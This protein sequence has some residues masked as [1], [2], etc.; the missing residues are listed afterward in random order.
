MATIVQP[1]TLSDQQRRRGI[2]ALMISNFFA[3]GGFFLIIPLIAVHY[4]ENLEWAAGTIGLLLAIRQFSQQALTTVFGVVCDRV[5]P[6]PLICLGMLVRAAG[7]ASMAIADTFILVLLSLL[8]AS[9]GGGMFESPKAAALAHLSDPQSRPR[10]YARMGVIG[11]L[12]VT[13]GTQLGA[14]LIKVDFAAVCLASTLA[15]LVIFLVNWFGLPSMKVSLGPVGSRAGLSMALHD[16]D[17][18]SFLLILTGYWFAWTQF[19]LTITL[20]A[21]DI[22]GTDSAVA[23]IYAVNTAITVGLGLFLPRLLE[24]WCAPVDLLAWGT[25]VLSI[26]L[27][28]V[29]FAQDTM[30][31]LIAA[32]IFS[33]GVVI[34]RPGQETVTANLADP[35]A[36]GTYFGVAAL[37]LAVGGG[38]GNLFGGIAYD[39]GRDHDLQVAPW[40]F[41]AA[42]GLAAAAGIRL[43]RQR[44]GVIREHR[45]PPGPSPHGEPARQ[46]KAA[47]PAE[48]LAGIAPRPLPGSKAAD[49]TSAANKPIA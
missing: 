46:G 26:G 42:V 2:A 48:H 16:R 10:L 40:L 47:S 33:I 32:A 27:A 9:L 29:G 24:R 39:A 38:L 19:S 25:L 44:F 1:T 17:F 13:V 22:A 6:R 14:I 18:V 30:T 36:R 5:G 43:N 4:V 23:W 21:T 49:R 37:S 11:G 41:F 7:F 8:L 34:A 31:V 35:A 12:G 15:Y 3:W 28:A 45:P 20:A